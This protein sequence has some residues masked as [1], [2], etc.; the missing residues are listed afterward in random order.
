[1]FC[2]WT[3]D[4]ILLFNAEINQSYW[5]DGTIEFIDNEGNEQ[6]TA[7]Y[8]KWVHDETNH[9][10][11]YSSSLAGTI[12]DAIG[13]KIVGDMDSLDFTAWASNDRAKAFQTQVWDA[14]KK[15]YDERKVPVSVI[16]AAACVST[17]MGATEEASHYNNVFGM[18][19]DFGDIQYSSGIAEITNTHM[20]QVIILLLLMHISSLALTQMLK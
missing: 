3:D 17:N 1:M 2:G 10:N 14:A 6:Q 4:Q 15:T 9:D 19:S 16:M 13:D 11:F 8:D 5:E 7:F 18:T 12:G 20:L